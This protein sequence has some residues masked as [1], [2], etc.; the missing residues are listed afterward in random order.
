MNPKSTHGLVDSIFKSGFFKHRDD[1][2]I[3]DWVL[4]TLV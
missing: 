3:G 1:P 4:W 2:T